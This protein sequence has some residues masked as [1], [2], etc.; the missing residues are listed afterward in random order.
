MKVLPFIFCLLCLTIKLCGQYQIVDQAVIGGT[1]DDRLYKIL[2]TENDGYIAIG[3]TTSSDLD[4]PRIAL[5][6]IWIRSLDKN[7]KLN[8][9]FIIGGYGTDN[10]L[11]AF[12]SN[13]NQLFISGTIN[14]TGGDVEQAFG[15][16]DAFIAK[17]DLEFALNDT[18][19]WFKTYG[20]PEFDSFE[21][22]V[23]SGKN[24]FGALGSILYTSATDGNYGSIV[25]THFD[26]DGNIIWEKK[27][28]SSMSDEGR[29]VIINQK[30]NYVISGYIRAAD[31]DVSEHIGAKDIWLAEIDLE[32]NLLWQK[33]LGGLKS[34]TPTGLIQHSSGA[35]VVVAETFSAFD[36]EY[37]NGDLL[38]VWVDEFSN[39]IYKVFGGSSL[40]VPKKVIELQN[41]NLV[42]IVE[43]FSVDGDVSSNYLAQDAWLLELDTELNILENKVFGGNQYDSF[44]DIFE[45]DESLIVCGFTDS[46]DGDLSYKHGNHDA[47]VAELSKV[48]VGTSTLEQN[49]NIDFKFHQKQIFVTAENVNSISLLDLSGKTIIQQKQNNILNINMI[50]PGIYILHIET[51][52]SKHSFKICVSE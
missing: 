9:D 17:V 34:E 25:F 3:I 41:G 52:T 28:D 19:K 8:W 42:V 29:N 51:N 16:N 7:F 37:G 35:Y 44:V 2:P 26:F 46:Y 47:W 32:G 18:L 38:L 50:L 49:K 36:N 43:S 21:R 11:D 40:E 39:P 4:V 24:T 48:K 20:T 22:I 23:Q 14:D 27:F 1:G 10:F 12:I 45:K 5:Q 13:D 15:V 33:T 31:G 30:G 6:D